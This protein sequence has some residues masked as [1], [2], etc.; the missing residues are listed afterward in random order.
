MKRLHKINTLIGLAFILQIA[1]IPSLAQ[2]QAKNESPGSS[3]SEQIKTV[4]EAIKLIK[5]PEPKF[6]PYQPTKIDNTQIAEMGFEQVYKSQPYKFKMRDGKHLYANRFERN[7]DTTILLLHGVLASSYTYNKTAGLL[8]E[9]TNAEIF[10]LDFRGHGASEGTPGDV[11]YIDQYADDVANVIA[12]IRK[13]KPNEKIILAGHSMGGGIALRFAMKKAASSVDGFL[14]FAPLLGQDSPTLPKE[15][16]NLTSTAEPFLKIHISRLIG[17]KMLNSVG[18]DQF[19]S[20]PILFFNL[21][22]ASPLKTYSYRSNESM[23]PVE[24]KKALKAVSKPLLVIVGSKDEAFV[25]EEYKKAVTEN[26]SGEVVL[27]KGATHN[28]IRHHQESIEAVQRWAEK[29]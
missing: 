18:I 13:N 10:A 1:I 9:A 17:L 26:S 14:L 24:Y 2:I 4:E 27:V 15:E 11:D 20:L 6:K 16:K 21:P 19:N 12:L 25:A 29:L 8:R 22:E 5:A 3:V 7:S 28:G 23:S